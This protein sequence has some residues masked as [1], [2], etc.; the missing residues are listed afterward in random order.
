[1]NTANQFPISEID[2]NN[3]E[4]LQ[5]LH[6]VFQRSYRVEAELLKAEVFP[7]LA[8]T[9]EQLK[10]DDSF[11]VGAWEGGRLA[12]AVELEQQAQQLEI[13]SLVVDPDYFRQGVASRLL[14]HVLS[15][16]RWKTARVET[17]TANEPAINLYRK[18]GFMERQRWHN[19]VGI[20]KLAMMVSKN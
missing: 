20:E 4:Q 14:A 17:A 9:A 1:M 2:L 11:F 18:F 15:E 12:A 10:T 5:Q 8:R 3:P 13:C 7:P 16:T 19:D 6:R